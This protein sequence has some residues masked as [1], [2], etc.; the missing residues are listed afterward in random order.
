M[1]KLVLA[2]LTAATLT[3][4]GGQASASTAPT[5]VV[6]DDKVECANADFA[7][8][9]AAVQAAEPGSV[10]RVCP[11]RYAESVTV[12]KPLTLRGQPDAVEAIGCFDPGFSQP[13]DLDPTRQAIVDGAGLFAQEL[14]RLRSDDIVL[15]GFVLQGA[16]SSPLPADFRLWRRAIDASD[17]FSGY[18][19]DHNLLRLNTVGIQF[20]SSGERGSRFDHNCL[21]EN[22]W[23]LATDERALVNARVDH[24]ATFRTQNF[25]FEP[26]LGR[27]ENVTFDQNHSRQDSGA[28]YLI[29][30]S[31][32]SNIVANTIEFRTS[33]DAW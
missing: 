10:V 5:L 31:V 33:D 2:V 26:A 6:D 4:G 9:Q 17:Q 22:G 18:R 32:T 29:R 13:S 30:N 20:G 11:G 3:I 21:R 27:I 14:F 7:S 23:G 8:I 25:A 12:D 19:I 16:S 24:N 28:S 15:R 1:R